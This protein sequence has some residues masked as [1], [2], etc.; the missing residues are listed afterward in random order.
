ML[1]TT[2]DL[3]DPVKVRMNG[4][5]EYLIQQNQRT[6]APPMEQ[7]R[8]SFEP[9]QNRLRKTDYR[10]KYNNNNN[11]NTN[12]THKEI[13]YIDQKGEKTTVR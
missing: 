1:A 7:R 3:N 4:T 10:H 9:P 2:V 13:Y 5:P 12:N 6:N 8:L 11:N